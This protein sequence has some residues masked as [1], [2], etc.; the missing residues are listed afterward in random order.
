[1]NQFESLSA[2]DRFAAIMDGLFQAITRRGSPGFSCANI[3]GP[4]LVLIWNRLCGIKSRFLRTLVT[5][6]APRRKPVLA[7]KSS[8]PASPGP[9]S[10]YRVPRHKAWLRR[11]IPETGGAASQL[12]H[13]LNQPDAIALIAA[14]HRLGRILRPLCHALSIRPSQV[15]CLYP[16]LAPAPPDAPPAMPPIAQAPPLAASAASPPQATPPHWPPIV[17]PLPA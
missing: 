10:P 13:F 7:R 1:M 9:A 11:L 17:P 14:D 4:L 3:A 12:C 8:K 2:A 6:Y 5:H 15:P 16:K